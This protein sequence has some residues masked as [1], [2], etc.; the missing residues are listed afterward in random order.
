MIVANLSMLTLDIFFDTFANTLL[1]SS[2]RYGTTLAVFLTL[3]ACL[4]I[5]RTCS[6]ST[7]SM[8][9]N[10]FLIFVQGSKP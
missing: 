5:P 6:R 8:I 1:T 4:S 3:E 10:G 7:L 9:Y 2:A